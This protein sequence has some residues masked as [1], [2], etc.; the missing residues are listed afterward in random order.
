MTEPIQIIRHKTLSDCLKAYGLS[1]RSRGYWK[2]ADHDGK[3]HITTHSKAL[4]LIRKRSCWGWT[5]KETIHVCVG[6]RAT[7]AQVINLLSHELG[8]I[9]RPFH[10][11]RYSEEQKASTYA[12]VALTAFSAAQDLLR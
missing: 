5:D 2:W 11:N 4:A 10:R 8:H 1:P 9:R 12:Y 7:L 3:R 6:K